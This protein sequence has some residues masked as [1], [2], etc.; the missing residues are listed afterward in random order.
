MPSIALTNT[1]VSPVWQSESHSAQKK[2]QTPTFLAHSLAH[3]GKKE[4]QAAIQHT[5]RK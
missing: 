1:F 3:S 5:N 2:T 4:N